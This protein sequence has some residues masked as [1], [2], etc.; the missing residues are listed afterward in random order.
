MGHL[1]RAKVEVAEPWTPGMKPGVT[2]E[3]ENPQGFV[4]RARE[5]DPKL[6]ASRLIIW[7]PFPP[8]PNAATLSDDQHSG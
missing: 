3:M 7:D 6:R 5:A 2:G 4:V 8:Q 1:E